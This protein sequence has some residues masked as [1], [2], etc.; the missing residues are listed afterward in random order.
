MLFQGVLMHGTAKHKLLALFA[1]ADASRDNVLSA[2]ELRD[3]FAFAMKVSNRNNPEYPGNPNVITD[4]QKTLIE[5]AVRAI[6]DIGDTD[7]VCS[8]SPPA[9]PLSLLLCAPLA[10]ACLLR[11]TVRSCWPSS[12]PLWTP[13]P[14]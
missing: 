2:D 1:I 13:T 7:K 11:R 14:S 6:F 12:W 8:A 5:N 3:S 9:N 4:E 10:H